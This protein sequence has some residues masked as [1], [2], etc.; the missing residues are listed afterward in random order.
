M[1]VLGKAV[2]TTLRGGICFDEQLNNDTNR[3]FL[4]A[5]GISAVVYYNESIPMLYLSG[6]AGYTF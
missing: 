6:M 3:F 4:T 2:T 1:R 5:Y